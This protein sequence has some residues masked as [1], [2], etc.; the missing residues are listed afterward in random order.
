MS[1]ITPII[2]WAGGKRQLLPVLKEK[3]P[4]KFNTY[5]EPFFGGGAFFFN[6]KSEGKINKSVINDLN[7]QLMN[8]Y[9]QIRDNKDE[10]IKILSTWRDEFNILTNQSLKD[11]YF[12]SKRTLYNKYLAD[13]KIDL[14]SACLFIF[15]NKTSFNGL[16][17]VNKKGF[18][19]VPSGHKTKISLFIPENMDKISDVLKDTNILTGN[20]DKACETAKKDDF[21]FFDSPYFDVF[22]SYQAN[23]FSKDDHIKLFNLF[24]KFSKDGVYCL[25]TNNDCSFIR[26]LYKNYN[27]ESVNVK[28]LINCDSSKRTGKEIVITNF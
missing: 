23:K 5:Y 6:L 19:N 28:R 20:F 18:Y 25:A 26:D 10:V 11:E 27:I 9:L 4:P 1:D 15:L 3:I 14:I 13:N 21:I 24:D 17:R 22:D 12:Y 8:L 16:Y 7:I 2:K